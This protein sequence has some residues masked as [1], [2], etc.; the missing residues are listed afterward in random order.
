MFILNLL[1]L[2]LIPKPP[3]IFSEVSERCI[4]MRYL[5]QDAPLMDRSKEKKSPE[6]N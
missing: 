6:Q 1:H 5:F 3:Y 4:Y 2:K